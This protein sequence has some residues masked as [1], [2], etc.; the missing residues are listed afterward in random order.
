LL[1]A[2][3]LRLQQREAGLAKKAEQLRKRERESTPW[4]QDESGPEINGADATP[5]SAAE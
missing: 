5:G 1:A 2:K 3:A 4:P